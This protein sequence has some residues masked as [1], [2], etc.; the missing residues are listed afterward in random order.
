MIVATK[1]VSASPFDGIPSH[2]FRAN[3]FSTV[4][5]KKPNPL[6][7]PPP[8]RAPP[9]HPR[10]DFPPPPSSLPPPVST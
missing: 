1:A 8:R 5:S 2:N 6:P 9:I 3:K 4:M 10:I 7:P